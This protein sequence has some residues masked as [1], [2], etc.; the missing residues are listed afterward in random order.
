MN[1][2]LI[3]TTNP[4]KLAEIRLFLSD[5]PV[6]LVSL[7]DVGITDNVEETGKTF[8]EN[9]IL[10]AKYYAQK[11]GLMTIADDGGFEI[12]ALGGEPGV[13]SHRWMDYTRESSDEELITYAFERMRSIPEGK[14][15]AQ[16]RLVLA[17]VTEKGDVITTVEEFVVGVV[18]MQRSPRKVEGFPYRSILFIP[19]M[20]KYYDQDLMTPEEADRYNHRKKAVNK[21]KPHI[22]FFLQQHP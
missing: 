7:K 5:L 15:Q 19:E 18:P 13:H 17:L 14:R 12:D 11:S 10:K 20:N 1:K 22:K 6:E 4:G 21:L 8:E 3:A 2:L 9:A 16:L